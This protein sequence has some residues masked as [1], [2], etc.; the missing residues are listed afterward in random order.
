MF[1][2]LVNT[3]CSQDLYFFSDHIY[4]AVTNSYICELMKM[5]TVVNTSNIGC[6]SKHCKSRSNMPEK[7]K[8]PDSSYCD[9]RR[10]FSLHMY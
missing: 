2:L 6:L 3:F 7:K 1:L 9:C 4:L 8:K 5:L 10:H